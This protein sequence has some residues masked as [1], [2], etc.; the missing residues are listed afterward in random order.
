MGGGGIFNNG[1]GVTR[2]PQCL[3]QSQIGAQSWMLSARSSLP[4]SDQPLSWH[5]PAE[6]QW[7]LL[8]IVTHH[9]ADLAMLRPII[10]LTDWAAI[11]EKQALAALG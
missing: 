2:Q 11:P 4:P 8:L 10:V 6:E 1:E 9:T 7:W 3:D 5:A